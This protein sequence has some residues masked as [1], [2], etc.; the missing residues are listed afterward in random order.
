[1]SETVLNRG[2]RP[3]KFKD[4]M[5]EQAFKLCLLGAKD[6]QLANFFGINEDTLNE[7]KKTKPGFSESLKAGKDEAD[8]AV[9]ASLYHKALGYEHQ[10]VKIVA[11]A[12]TGAEHIVE[13]I[14]R[15]APD[16]TAAIFWLKN[17]QKEQWRD[18][19]E[20]DITTGGDKIGA[21]SADQADQLIRARAARNSGNL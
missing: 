12:K 5:N 17:R 10:A 13:Y 1:M 4:E 21:L 14:E 15:Y 7:W 8:A 3:T 11:D 16:T 6:A 19:T 20:N 18:K 9:A 2:G